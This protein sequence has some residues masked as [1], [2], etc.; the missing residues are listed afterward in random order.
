[1]NQKAKEINVCHFDR[2]KWVY[3]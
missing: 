3:M 1:M 2:D